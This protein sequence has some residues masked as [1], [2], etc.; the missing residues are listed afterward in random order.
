MIK[1]FLSK[2]YDWSDERALHLNGLSHFV[3]LLHEEWEGVPSFPGSTPMNRRQGSIHMKDEALLR[4]KPATADHKT[5]Y[6]QRYLID[7]CGQWITNCPDSPLKSILFIVSWNMFIY[8]HIHYILS[9]TIHLQLILI[10][11]PRFYI[12]VSY[13]YRIRLTL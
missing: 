1:Q 3:V 11:F 7:S 2:V 12:W 5:I 9:I 4:Y 8:V 13:K 6:S 10:L